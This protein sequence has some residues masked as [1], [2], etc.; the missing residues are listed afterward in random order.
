M[1]LSSQPLVSVVM[2]VYNGESYLT[3]AINSIIRQSFEDFELIVI[4]DSSTDNTLEILNQFVKIDSRIRIIA[5]NSRVGLTRSLI[6]G[7]SKARGVLIARHDADDISVRERFANQVEYLN[8]HTDFGLIGTA[9]TR[10]DSYGKEIAH[11][12]VIRGNKKIKRLLRGGN[13]FAHGSVMVRKKVIETVG[14]YRSGFSYAQDYD[15]W[16]RIAEV[17]CLDNLP[18]RLY[19]WRTHSSG[20]SEEKQFEQLKYAALAALFAKQRNNR[21]EES[22]YKLEASPG[23]INNFL[24]N[25]E[26]TG[27]FNAFIGRILLRMGKREMGCEY[28]SK[29]KG[30]SNKIYYKLCQNESLFHKFRDM[31]RYLVSLSGWKG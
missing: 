10:I 11:P 7:L 15:L 6:N 2:S 24:S 19:L 26:L 31:S 13:V 14:G 9:V 23:E 18:N 8:K 17:C 29:S 3:D 12:I 5:Q 20:I 27:E 25:A 16:L 4:D 21:I 1:K 30:I 22:Y 28:L